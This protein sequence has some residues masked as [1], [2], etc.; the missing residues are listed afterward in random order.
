MY[1]YN[2]SGHPVEGIEFA[3]FIGINFGSSAESIRE[4]IQKTLTGLPNR[5]ALLR[6]ERASIVLPG[7]THVGAILLAEWH[8][9]FGNW[10]TIRWAVRTENGF[11]YTDDSTADLNAIRELARTFRLL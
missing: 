1:E 10:P 2:F 7:W 6:G 5:N 8:G 11:S 9:Q 4:V 3:P